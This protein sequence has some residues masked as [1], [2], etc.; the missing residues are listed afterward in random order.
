MK[1]YNC[2][3]CEYR[4]LA[5]SRSVVSVMEAHEPGARVAALRLS[6]GEKTDGEEMLLLDIGRDECCWT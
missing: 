3:M 6:G 5:C 4:R 2:S 1:R